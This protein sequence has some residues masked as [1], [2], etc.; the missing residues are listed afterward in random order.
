MP[1]NSRGVYPVLAGI[2]CVSKVVDNSRD[3]FAPVDGWVLQSKSLQNC[4]NFTDVSL[5]NTVGLGA[6]GC[7]LDLRPTK[8]I[9][10]VIDCALELF[11]EVTADSMGNV[12]VRKNRYQSLN[13]MLC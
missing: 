13:D 6:S 4:F 7:R 1:S 9:A 5:G 12:A 2:D 8:E 3:D 11:A 10:K